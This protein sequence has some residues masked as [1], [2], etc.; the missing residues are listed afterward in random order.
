M[1]HRALRAKVW[2]RAENRCEYCRMPQDCDPIPF[3]LDH[4]VAQKHRGKTQLNNLAVACFHCNNHKGPNLAG[5]DPKSHRMIRLFHP[6]QDHWEK[7]FRLADDGRILGLTAIGR[8]TIE[9]LCINLSHRVE[10]R[11]SLLEE[12]K[13]SLVVE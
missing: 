2:A 12:G 11:L 13:L 6:R 7:H 8:T 9:V 3:E 4:I 5:V 10:H 1:T